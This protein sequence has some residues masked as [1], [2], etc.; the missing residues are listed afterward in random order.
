MLQDVVDRAAAGQ[1]FDLRK[2]SYILGES[3]S[4]YKNFVDKRVP[5]VFFSDST[6]PVLPHHR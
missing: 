2:V 6:G 1:D 5:T 3:R 4:D